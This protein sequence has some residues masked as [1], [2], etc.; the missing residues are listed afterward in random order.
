MKNFIFLWLLLAG[1]A[2]GAAKDDA[3]VSASQQAESNLS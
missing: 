1:Y 3:R 2:F